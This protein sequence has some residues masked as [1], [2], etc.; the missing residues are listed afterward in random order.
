MNSG[1]AQVGTQSE[2]RIAVVA[3]GTAV[4]V[5]VGSLFGQNLVGDVV[6]VVTGGM[7]TLAVG[8]TVGILRLVNGIFGAIGVVRP[9]AAISS[10][11]LVDSRL[12][13]TEIAQ[14]QFV[15]LQTVVEIADVP[16]LV[17]FRFRLEHLIPMPAG[18]GYP[19]MR[20]AANPAASSL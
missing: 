3:V 11:H 5:A 18:V 15:D 2:L 4:G 1:L 6:A 7:T 10:V 12:V 8:V 20:A 19:P 13:L 9:A 17:G 16:M 14:E